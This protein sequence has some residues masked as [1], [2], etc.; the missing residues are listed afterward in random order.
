MVGLLGR[1]VASSLGSTIWGEL[2]LL[3]GSAG[4]TRGWGSGGGGRKGEGDLR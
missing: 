4:C 3:R 2:D 1:R